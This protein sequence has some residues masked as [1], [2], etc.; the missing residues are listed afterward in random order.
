[1]DQPA[2]SALSG[3]AAALAAAGAPVAA[4]RQ[5]DEFT[6]EEAA[7]EMGKSLCVARKTLARLMTEG[8]AT[9]RHAT[10]N[11]TAGFLYRLK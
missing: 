8:K 4:P 7:L 5:P 9:R 6:A 1:M 10:L 3:L 2:R 11:A